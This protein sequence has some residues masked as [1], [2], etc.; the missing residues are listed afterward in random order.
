MVVSIVMLAMTALYLIIVLL[1][2]FGLNI[3]NTRIAVVT[4]G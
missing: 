1:P 2:N 4:Y 3:F